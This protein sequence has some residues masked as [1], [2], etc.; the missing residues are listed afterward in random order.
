M[1][2][3]AV[4]DGGVSWVWCGAGARLSLQL[5]LWRVPSPSNGACAQ[6]SLWW[7]GPEISEASAE[8]LNRAATVVH[9][10]ASPSAKRTT[11]RFPS[12]Q[13]APGMAKGSLA[14]VPSFAC[15]PNYSAPNSRIGA[16]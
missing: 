7:W 6:M 14:I 8:T 11:L 1:W 15:I 16:Q 12:A 13:G 4:D 3:W 9:T 2:A 5:P 10:I